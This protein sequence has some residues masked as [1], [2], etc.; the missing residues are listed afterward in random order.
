MKSH[1]LVS[2]LDHYLSIESIEDDSNNGLQV[3][4]EGEINTVGFAVDACMDVFRKALSEKCDLIVVHH[5]M[6]WGGIRYIR[7]N[8]FERVHFLIRNTIGLYAVHLP[9]DIHKEVGNNV[10]M[11]HLIG[12]E[13]TGEFC[14]YKNN[15]IGLICEGNAPLSHI[16]ERID[17][18]FNSHRLWKFGN[19]TCRK[20]GIITGSGTYCL[21]AAIEEG[22]DTF[23]S[24]EP[25]H[26]AYHQARENKLNV[27]FAGHYQ[28]ETLGVKAL[29]QKINT[30][31]PVTTVFLDSPTGL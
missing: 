13:S 26:M 22:C 14:T 31:F 20:I 4:V 6:I 10:Q 8:T 1:E 5:G 19:D 17:A 29:M 7:G 2:F 27:L 21:E 11:A 25:K 24:G 9:L 12:F 3:E 15:K 30:M 28:T 18:A 23:I 16:V